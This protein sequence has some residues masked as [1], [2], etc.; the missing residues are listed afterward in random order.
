MFDKLLAGKKFMLRSPKHNRNQIWL[1]PTLPPFNFIL[2]KKIFY[3]VI[4]QSNFARWT[5]Q[6]LLA[7]LCFTFTRLAIITRQT[8]TKID[9][10][11]GGEIE[12]EPY[13]ALKSATKKQID[14]GITLPH[15]DKAELRTTCDTTQT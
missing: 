8:L 4:I 10:L 9:N 12:K 2:E 1:F 15:R 13:F 3:V 14:K 5:N 7:D 6:Q 11:N